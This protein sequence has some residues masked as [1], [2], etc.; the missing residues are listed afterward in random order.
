MHEERTR[1]VP[2]HVDM[3]PAAVGQRLR[4]VAQLYRLGVSLRTARVLGGV[5][6]L[7][8]SIARQRNEDDASSRETDRQPAAE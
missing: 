7:R 4:E 8:L 5:D 1:T 3:S 2:N 6:E